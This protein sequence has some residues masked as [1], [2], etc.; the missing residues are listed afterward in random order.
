MKIVNLCRSCS[1]TVSAGIC[2]F[3]VNDIGNRKIYEICSKLTLKTPE[4]TY[5]THFFSVFI[6]GFEQ[7]NAGW[8]DC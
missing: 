4:R 8:L 3:K 5:F 6:V 1:S 7:V 2:L